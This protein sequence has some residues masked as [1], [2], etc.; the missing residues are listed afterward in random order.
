MGLAAHATGQ[1]GM[2]ASVLS[3]DEPIN[4][5]VPWRWFCAAGWQTSATMHAMEP[6]RVFAARPAPEATA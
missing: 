6:A 1:A 5:F 3:L 4:T 2:F